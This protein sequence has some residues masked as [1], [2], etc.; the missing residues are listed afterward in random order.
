[1]FCEIIDL[2]NAS[3]C[4]FRFSCE[5]DINECLFHSCLNNA[6]CIDGI[7]SFRCQCKPGYEGVFCGNETNECESMPCLNNG[8][9]MDQINGFK[10]SCQP[11]FT[12]KQCAIDINDCVNQPCENN[13]TCLDLVNGYQCLC[14]EGTD[15]SF[16][17]ILQFVLNNYVWA[18][19]LH[20][21]IIDDLGSLSLIRN[22][23]T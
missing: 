14:E 21:I 15:C 6:S 4:L 23:S 5:E 19:E 3:T 12:G 9:C 1:M 10:C 22:L 11:G 2:S 8:T 13:G 7:A 17:N 16:V 18:C 20:V